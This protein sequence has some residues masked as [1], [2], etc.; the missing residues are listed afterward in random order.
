MV[1]VTDRRRALVLLIAGVLIAGA[2]VA[3]VAVRGKHSDSDG[4]AATNPI[5]T[6]PP[7]TTA[8]TTPAATTPPTTVAATTAPATVTGVVD[9]SA[10]TTRLDPHEI[11]S[12]PMPPPGDLL[13]AAYVAVAPNN[14][15]AILNDITGVVR[16]IDGTTRM[17]I[18][19]Y[20]TTVPTIGSQDFVANGFL[21]GPDDVLYVDESDASGSR[22]VVALARKGDSYTE[23]ARAA[24]A[25]DVGTL[26]LGRTGVV[27]VGS[28]EPILAYV[29]AD[30]QPSA[31]TIDT[32]D[33]TLASPAKDAYT[34]QRGGD[35]WNVTYQFP[36]DA[37]LPPSDTCVLCPDA[38][39]GVGS[40]VVLVNQSPAAGGDLQT[41]LTVLSDTITTYDVDWN[42]VGVLGD[43]LLFDRFDQ[44]S[45]DL[46]TVEI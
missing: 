18:T 1:R 27:G 39:L 21:V 10:A 7:T 30:G 43:A 14:R 2:I 29:G 46:G 22:A 34:V 45:L 11:V 8:V 15:I 26:R 9:L 3:I 24:H 41:K 20:K 16:F 25:A 13:P 31:A 33:V 44:D 17:D 32:D 42:F 6:T 38:Y 36:S 35:T 37:G 28:P 40:A 19:Q 23:V 12:F 5:S 4:T